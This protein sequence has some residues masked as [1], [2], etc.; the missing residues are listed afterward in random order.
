M[1]KLFTC[2]SCA[3]FREH[4]VLNKDGIC[5]LVP[6]KPKYVFK[7]QHCKVWKDRKTGLDAAKMMKKIGGS[8]CS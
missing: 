2:E 7:S 5:F 6:K 8:S 4:K 1:A 3:R